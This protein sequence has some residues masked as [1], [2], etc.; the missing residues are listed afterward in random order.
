[1]VVLSCISKTSDSLP[2]CGVGASIVEVD[3]DRIRPVAHAVH[4]ISGTGGAGDGV[5]D[6]AAIAEVSLP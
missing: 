2:G 4:D 6:V 3:P 1:M 5:I